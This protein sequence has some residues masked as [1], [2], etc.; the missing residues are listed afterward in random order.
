MWYAVKTMQPKIEQFLTRHR[1]PFNSVQLRDAW[2]VFRSSLPLDDNWR[3][4]PGQ[5]LQTH[6][7]VAF[8][9]QQVEELSRDATLN[10]SSRQLPMTE[11]EYQTLVGQ[12]PS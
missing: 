4:M 7:A 9:P 6:L 11:V 2:K 8:T 3:T 5:F 12:S 10:P 1:I